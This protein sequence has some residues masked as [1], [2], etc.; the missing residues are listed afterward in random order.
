MV[1]PRYFVHRPLDSVS[2]PRGLVGSEVEEVNNYGAFHEGV[3]PPSTFYL[4]VQ[5]LGYGNLNQCGASCKV[6]R[7]R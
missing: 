5:R 3:R 4:V 1:F 2:K 6:V 7:L